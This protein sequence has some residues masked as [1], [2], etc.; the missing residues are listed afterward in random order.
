MLHKQNFTWLLVFYSFL[1]RV[2]K[3]LVNMT[4]IYCILFSLLLWDMI[5]TDET[6]EI[7]W[8]ILISSEQRKGI[9]DAPN[10]IELIKIKSSH[11]E[12]ETLMIVFYVSETSILSFILLSNKTLM[13]KFISMLEL[14]LSCAWYFIEHVIIYVWN[15]VFF[16]Y[17]AELCI[18]INNYVLHITFYHCTYSF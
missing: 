2:E 4:I 8:N 15:D 11:T 5:I 3:F 16:F 10:R 17:L 13:W 7:W 6:K 1:E 14:I 9:F 12:R 18:G